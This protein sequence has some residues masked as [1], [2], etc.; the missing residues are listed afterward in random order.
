LL[1]EPLR[2]FANSLVCDYGRDV[3]EVAKL[4]DIEPAWTP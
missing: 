3:G 4:L 1:V 2:D